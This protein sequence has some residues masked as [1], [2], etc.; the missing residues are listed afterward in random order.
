VNGKPAGERWFVAM[1]AVATIGIVFVHLI[2]ALIGAL[3]ETAVPSP[4]LALAT[5]TCGMVATV[6]GGIARR[7][8]VA[9]AA[10]LAASA[11]CALAIGGAWM[12][13]MPAMLAGGLLAGVLLPWLAVR[14]PRELDG[15]LGRHPVLS[16]LWAILGLVCIAQT[17]RF[18]SF[19]SD[20]SL[21]WGSTFPPIPEGAEHMC[22]AAYVRAGELAAVGE[23][24]LYDPAHYAAGMPS[25][26]HGLSSYLGD[27][28]LYPPP[29]VMLPRAALAVTDDFLL[30]RTVWFALQAF[31]LAA[32]LIAIARWVGGREGRRAALLAPLVWI[33]IP[34]MLD[35]QFGQFHLFAIICAIGAMVAFAERRPM[36][37]GALL[38]WAIVTKLF[39]GILIVYLLARRQW[40]AAAIASGF[41][42]AFCGAALLVLGPAPFEA[43]LEFQLPRISS[44]EAFAFFEAGPSTISDNYSA[45]GLVF[46][47]RE[48]GVPGMTRELAAI[49][50]WVYSAGLV[51]L[52]IVAARRTRDRKGEVLVWLGLIGLAALRSP[53]APNIY[54]SSSTI[55]LLTF[56]DTPSRKARVGWAVAWLLVQGSL[57]VPDA[58][59]MV[60]SSMIGQAITFALLVW[61]VLRRGRAA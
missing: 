59:V 25:S 46:K 29:F 34:V 30:V 42:I 31:A 11:L 14:L 39:P 43:F 16:V 21:I 2:A 40:R 44:G 27:P 41:A 37:G 35:L 32:A 61:T 24:N 17:A 7:P 10:S 54:V 23:P 58:Q 8:Q 45:Y 26:V 49:V 50:S 20:P 57:P 22:M 36:L 18:S 28:F 33:A 38:G 19:M 60:A 3:I 15:S 6:A 55:W 12:V 56:V 1:V 5:V 48:L 52:A 53:F 4:A 13:A 9:L 51:V 47:L